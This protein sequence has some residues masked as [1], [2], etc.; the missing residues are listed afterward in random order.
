MLLDSVWN[1]SEEA[2][3]KAMKRIGMTHEPSLGHRSFSPAISSTYRAYPLPRKALWRSPDASTA[4]PL[5]T[6]SRQ[7]FVLGLA[8][9]CLYP[10]D[11][12]PGTNGLKQ[13][14]SGFDPDVSWRSRS[15]RF[16]SRR[17]SSSH[18]HLRISAR[19]SPSSTRQAIVVAPL[20]GSRLT[21]SF[22]REEKGIS[23]IQR[24]IEHRPRYHEIHQAPL[25]RL[26]VATVDHLSLD[27][28]I[29]NTADQRM[30]G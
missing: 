28:E 11:V 4:H 20:S 19:R 14:L 18:Y 27:K 17:R 3:A 1:S 13:L 15:H 8:E 2:Q 30:A 6:L 16:S 26:Q 12:I 9:N 7:G 29:P 5:L 22:Q 24:I 10:P 23:R 21:C 25:R